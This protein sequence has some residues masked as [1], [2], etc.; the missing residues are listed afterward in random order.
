[1][2]FLLFFSIMIL[3][4]IDLFIFVLISFTY[5]KKEIKEIY[6]ALKNNG[7]QIKKMIRIKKFH[8][9]YETKNRGN[10]EFKLF[11]LKRINSLKNENLSRLITQ[12]ITFDSYRKIN[13]KSFNI[14]DKNSD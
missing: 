7:E 8:N 3:Y 11:N 5:I 10:K 13:T 9:K 2:D 12:N 6:Y 1:M 4:F 14:I